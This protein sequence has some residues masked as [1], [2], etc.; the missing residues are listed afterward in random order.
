VSEGRK[1]LLVIGYAAILGGV[2]VRTES[3]LPATNLCGFMAM[4]AEQPMPV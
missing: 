3:A 4:R 1:G 2:L